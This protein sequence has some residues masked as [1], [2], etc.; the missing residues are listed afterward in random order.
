M[1]LWALPGAIQDTLETGRIHLFSRQFFEEL[2]RRFSGPGRRRFIVQ[3]L[4]AIL[5]GVRCGLADAKSG[6]SPYIATLLFHGHKR[7]KLLRSGIAAIGHVVAIGILLDAVAQ[8][9][10][11]KQVHPGAALVI[12]PLLVCVPYAM[13]RGLTLRLAR[14]LKP[15]QPVTP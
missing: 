8:L 7:K 14:R 2:P 12:G 10:I 15:Q 4:V 6:Q 5:L 3:P 11:Y 9:L 13:A 1:I